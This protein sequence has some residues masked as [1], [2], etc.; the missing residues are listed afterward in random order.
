MPIFAKKKEFTGWEAPPSIP[1]R[2]IWDNEGLK[3]FVHLALQSPSS[4]QTKST[5]EE[6]VTK[7]KYE[8]AMKMY[9]IVYEFVT[10]YGADIVGLQQALY[11]IL[12]DYTSSIQSTCRHAPKYELFATFLAAWR[13]WK[14][15]CRILHF[16]FRPVDVIWIPILKTSTL[17]KVMDG[18]N[19][20]LDINSLFLELWRTNV[21]VPLSMQM[22]DLALELLREEHNGVTTSSAGL[23]ACMACYTRELNYKSISEKFETAYIEETEKFYGELAKNPK[24]M[25]DGQ[26]FVKII[27]E[28]YE[29][30]TQYA[31]LRLRDAAVDRVNDALDKLFLMGNESLFESMFIPALRRDNVD[32][33]RN[34]YQIILRANAMKTPDKSDGVFLRLPMTMSAKDNTCKLFQRFVRAKIQQSIDE[35]AAVSAKKGVDSFERFAESILSQYTHFSMIVQNSFGDDIAFRD[36]LEAIVTET[37][38]NMSSDEKGTGEDSLKNVAVA[39]ARYCDKTLRKRK[40]PLTPDEIEARQRGVIVLLRKFSAKDLFMRQYEKFFA[41]RVFVQASIGALQ[42]AE[43]VVKMCKA[44]GSSFVSRLMTMIHD[45]TANGEIM[46][47]FH[48]SKLSANA[49]VDAFAVNASNWPI[50]SGSH[51]TVTLP[52]NVQQWLVAFDKFYSSKFPERKIEHLHHLGRAEVRYNITDTRSVMLVLSAYQVSMLSLYSRSSTTLELSEIV[53]RCSIPKVVVRR[54]LK[55]LIIHGLLTASDLTLASDSTKLSLNPKFT[56]PEGVEQQSMLI[57][58][59][60]D[61][62]LKQLQTTL[63][64]S[65]S[66]SVSW[67]DQSDVYHPP[68]EAAAAAATTNTTAAP[69]EDDGLLSDDALTE[70][71]EKERQALLQAAV[72]R[73]LKRSKTMKVTELLNKVSSMLATNFQ[74]T[75]PMLKTAIATLK[76]LNFVDF[77]SS[78]GKVDYIP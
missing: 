73:V 8:D 71:I 49:P 55:P 35:D 56:L 74:V 24:L 48:N 52:S 68:A 42:E 66:T 47:A 70:M 7:K 38:N 31:R 14:Q 23:T 10:S 36:A 1:Y 4:I 27:C 17:S 51:P 45:T 61:F 33:I 44:Q 15:S 78:S 77:D 37:L 13:Q 12:V 62:R 29:R 53:K 50:S 28:T 6:K 26:T 57:D 41:Q 60:D 3:D 30:E 58:P 76:Q 64:S 19:P 20:T 9:N 2:T 63:A 21:A 5:D 40:H 69:A 46:S 43:M 75:Q 11:F 65:I 67:R 18:S 22:R 72:M 16:V 25:R 54:Q 39:L 59:K 32:E 34:I